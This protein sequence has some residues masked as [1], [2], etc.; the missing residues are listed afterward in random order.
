MSYIRVE[1]RGNGLDTA[2]R[3]PSPE[4]TGNQGGNQVQTGPEVTLAVDNKDEVYWWLHYHKLHES[5][6]YFKGMTH[7]RIRSRMMT[8]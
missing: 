2:S 8:S 3:S 7:N 5:H 6:K 4:V 1:M